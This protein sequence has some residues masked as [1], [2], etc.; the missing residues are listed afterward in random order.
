[1]PVVCGGLYG[2]AYEMEK[3]GNDCKL[4][5]NGTWESIGKLVTNVNVF[6][7]IGRVKGQFYLN[8]HYM[9]NGDVLLYGN[10]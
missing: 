4:L 2:N 5:R 6:P 10:K 8:V 9:E 3:F 1:M 7:N